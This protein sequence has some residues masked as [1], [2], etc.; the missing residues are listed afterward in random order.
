MR[1]DA[2]DHR[3]TVSTGDD[4][5]RYGNPAAL[6]AEV[7]V[8]RAIYDAFARR[9]VEGALAYISPDAECH[10]TG[11]AARVQRDGPY[12]GHDGVREYFADA[13]RAW[14]DLRIVADDLR[15]TLGGV[16]VFGHVEASADGH[17]VRVNAI[18]SWQV[19]DGLATRMRV[20]SLG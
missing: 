16:V 8:V 4:L 11:T 9:D 3:G 13:A 2:D 17:P 14:D 18:W 7:D 6:T 5:G 12:R 15:A 19:R 20:D 10:V 1:A